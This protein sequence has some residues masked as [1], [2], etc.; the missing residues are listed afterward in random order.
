MRQWVIRGLL[1][2]L[3]VGLIGGSF[4]DA[5][6]PK[7]KTSAK[8]KKAWFTK[9][10]TTT[11]LTDFLDDANVVGPPRQGDLGT[12]DATAIFETVTVEQ[13]FCGHTICST[14]HKTLTVLFESAVAEFED[15]TVPDGDIIEVTLNSQ[16]NGE[17]ALPPVTFSNG[18]AF[19]KLSTKNGDV[20]PNVVEG[21]SMDYDFL[22]QVTTSFG[23]D[24][25]VVTVT[26][27]S[28]K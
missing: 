13:K 21:D 1:L 8:K 3:A 26:T 12:F 7:G 22:F 23:F 16:A 28:G 10:V 18:Q 5:A 15:G 14:T 25:P 2:S 9:T 24:A 17:I 27:T 11:V 4:V 20:V 6:G 19:L